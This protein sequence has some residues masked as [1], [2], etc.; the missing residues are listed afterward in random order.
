[1]TWYRVYKTFRGGKSPIDYIEVP[2][3]SRTNIVKSH[4][5]E[6]AENTDGGHCYGWT[7][8]WKKVKMPSKKWLLE[9]VKSLKNN[10]PYYKERIEK[11][12]EKIKEIK[13]YL[14]TK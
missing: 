3:Y 8:Y 10:I 1:M 4:A 13:S 14:K 9:E 11:C 7:V 12:K 6:W 2:K 5:E